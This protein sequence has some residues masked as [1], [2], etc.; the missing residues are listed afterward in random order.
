MRPEPQPRREHRG[1]SNNE[2]EFVNRG[3]RREEM[4]RAER[5]EFRN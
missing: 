5:E 2:E 4:R 1:H 3:L